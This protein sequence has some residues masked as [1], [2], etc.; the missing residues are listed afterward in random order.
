MNR[1]LVIVTMLITLSVGAQSSEK[2]NSAY[3]TYYRG[4]ELFEKE[5]YSAA[6]KEFRNFIDQFGQKNDP[7]YLKALYYEGVSALE[8]F[9]NDGVLLLENFNK[10]YPESIYRTKIYY[11]LGR[12]YYQKKEFPQAIAWFNKLHAS[13]IEPDDKD[14]FYFKLGYANFQEQNLSGAR[15]AFYEIRNS[16]SQYGAPA[17]YYY[18]HIAYREKSYQTALEGF[19]KLLSDTRF[20]EV[21]PYYITQIYYL[22]GRYDDVTRFAPTLIDSVKSTSIND[23]NHL[24]GDAFY[25]VGK[26]DEAVMYLEKFNNKE[27]TSREE[28]YQLGYANYRSSNFDKAIQLFDKVSQ[29]KDTLGQIAFY[30]I[31]EC[32][33]K[34]GN[35]AYARTAF[36]AASMID[37]DA[38]IQEDALYNYAVLS[39]KLDINPYD[40]AVEALG[41]YLKKYPNSDRKNEVY[42]YLVTVYTS[43]NNYAA[44][45]KSLD[46][47][48]TKDIRLKTAYQLVAY[49][50]GVELYQKASFLKAIDA[51]N[52]V[53]KY[54]IDAEIAAKAN[55]W[56]AD[57]YYQLKNYPKAVQGFK[58][59][60]ALPGNYSSQ[61]RADAYYNLGYA[62][63]NTAQKPENNPLMEDAFKDYLGQNS[64]KDKIKKADAHMR[65]ADYY[66]I[67]KKNEL[68]IKHYKEVYD[69]K[70]GNEDQALFYMALTYGL[71]EKGTDEKIKNLQDIVNNY[72]RS[73][74]MIHSIYEIGIS[75]RA[76]EQDE[77]AYP[78]FQELV[79]DYPTSLLIREAYINMAD[80]LYKR[81]DFAKS[82]E[83]FKKIIADYGTDREVCLTCVK[84]LSNIYKAQKQLDKIEDLRVYSCSDEVVDDLEDS[85]YN[86]AMEPYMDSSF[87]EAI[88][89]LN[90]YLEKYKGGK[91]E[92]EITAYLANAYFRTGN[93]AKALEMYKVLLEKPTTEFTELAALRV[94]KNLYNSGEYESALYYY[95]KLEKVS[96][97]PVIIHNTQIGLMRCH[98]YLENWANAAEYS[99]KVLTNAL[100][101]S[102][103]RM[104]AEYVKG[105][106][107]Y[108]EEN[109]AEAKP[110]LEWIVKNASNE[111]A[112]EAKFYIAEMYYK[113]KD[114]TK[115]EAEIRALLKMK[116]AYDFWT[117]KALILQSKVLIAKLDLF[118][119]EH[120]L[121]SVI[122]NYTVQ[123]DGIL[124]EANQLWDEL[125]QLKTAPKTVEEK[126]TTVIEIN[127][128]E[129]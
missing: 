39:Y 84:G 81:K 55:F 9:N 122:D 118:Q 126:K 61:L 71:T 58:S 105:I 68:A 87:V 1:L 67:S 44:A 57:S 101:S 86:A 8:L 10:N 46:K 127:E 53:D 119:A 121:R 116:P 18:S 37:V 59:F 83:M 25:R 5:Q 48:A 123:D 2:Y 21:V 62:Y 79:T 117:A 100:I 15:A 109:F 112:P 128:K 24:I 33:L 41:L 52:L 70:P 60:L 6:R 49:N 107:N 31:G 98:F 120:T 11:K 40:E 38:K 103:I 32:Y 12:Y 74:Y 43:T 72:P 76:K 115:A 20:K 34:K 80:I 47:L 13:E 65:L 36:E 45:L 23:M 110:S 30:H 35:N 104:E 94:S 129:K 85:Y 14:E 16:S 63:L 102:S 91:Y 97:Q 28:D 93:E 106:A 27:N 19:E 78:Y 108:H 114:P 96:S 77:K 51:F 29:T 73:Q 4:E 42:Q 99:K 26:Y 113:Q 90:K 95:D 54:P 92:L 56:I 7:F 111:M 124:Q 3:A 89:D 69:L 88:P 22:Q 66:Y 75:Y 82:E 64:L 50:Y 125:M 17:L